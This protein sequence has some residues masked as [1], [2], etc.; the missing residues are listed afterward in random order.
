MKILY[1][2]RWLAA[3]VHAQR[4][5]KSVYTDIQG[6]LNI[7]SLEDVSFYTYL[8]SR[9]SDLLPEGIT[10]TFESVGNDLLDQI[11]KLDVTNSVMG[12]WLDYDLQKRSKPDDLESR[13][14]TCDLA[15]MDKRENILIFSHIRPS[16]AAL[17]E[18]GPNALLWLYDRT[19]R[20]YSA[21]ASPEV[22]ADTPLFLHYQRTLGLSINPSHR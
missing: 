3:A 19:I 17:K 4:A 5:P 6:L 15:G 20:I 22:L 21:F 11:Q 14:L 16:E 13:I 1:V 9:L 7:V 10:G 12:P 18:V 8:N 2:P